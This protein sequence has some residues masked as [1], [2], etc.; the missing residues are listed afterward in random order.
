MSCWRKYK[1]EVLKNVKRKF[2]KE[3]CKEMG[4]ELDYNTH[5]ISGY[6]NEYADVT[7]T[8]VKSGKKLPLGFILQEKGGKT[9]LTL[10]GDFW[11]TGLNESV[12][13]DKLA[14]TYQ[15]IHIK[16]ELQRHGFSIESINTNNK[17]EIELIA[18]C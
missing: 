3:A 1:S 17:E 11:N 16:T 12:F 10:E 2:L 14:Q 18:C 8:L 15:K 9:E 6:Y 13:M 7:C 4:L 5:R